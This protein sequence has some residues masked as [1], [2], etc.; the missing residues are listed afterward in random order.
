MP[1]EPNWNISY[2]ICRNNQSPIEPIL[3]FEIPITDNQVVYMEQ[4][5]YKRPFCDE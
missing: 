3:L 5:I 4:A 2:E 1:M